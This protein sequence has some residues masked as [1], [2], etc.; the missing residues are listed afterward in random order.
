MMKITKKVFMLLV[1]AAVSAVC[2][3]A[4]GKRMMPEATE[5]INQISVTPTDMPHNKVSFSGVPSVMGKIVKVNMYDK[6][7]TVKN[8][9]SDTVVVKINP[10]TRIFLAVRDAADSSIVNMYADGKHCNLGDLQAGNWVAVSTYPTDTKVVDATC[11]FSIRTVENLG[12][13]ENSREANAK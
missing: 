3:F 9:D 12:K 1:V 6:S 7:I 4:E 13:V 2:V 10:T 11:I 8:S 5:S